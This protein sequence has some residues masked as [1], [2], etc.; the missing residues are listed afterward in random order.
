MVKAYYTARILT[1][2]EPKGHESA[3]LRA[4][5]AGD[6]RTF[7]IFGGQGYEEYFDELTSLYN[8]YSVLVGEFVQ[9]LAAHLLQ[10]SGS[11]EARKVYGKGLDVMS[12]ILDPQDRPDGEYLSSAPVSLPCVGVVQLALYAVTCR[13]LG[14][15]P[16]DLRKYFS[17]IQS[18]YPTNMYRRHRSFSRN[19]HCSRS[20]SILRLDILPNPIQNRINNPLPHRSPIPNGLPSN[21]SPPFHPRRRIIQQRRKPV[22]NVIYP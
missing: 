11:E 7:L 3:L 18:H 14:K 10:L 19:C 6:A 4:V 5:T 8:T 17:G 1:G 20:R 12:W 2:R 21:H 16:G 13:V 9:H 15:T 22:T